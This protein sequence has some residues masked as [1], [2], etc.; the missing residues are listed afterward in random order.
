[1]YHDM[2]CCTGFPC[3]LLRG[4]PLLSEAPAVD[5]SPELAEAKHQSITTALPSLEANRGCEG[6]SPTRVILTGDA[7]KD[8]DES[9][10]LEL[11]LSDYE[12]KH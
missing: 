3:K 11:H 6:F 7:N 4:G 2:A 9:T 12:E 1:M 10:N 8:R 5:N